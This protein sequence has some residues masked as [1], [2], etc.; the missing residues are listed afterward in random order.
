VQRS[1]IHSNLGSEVIIFSIK[2][3]E[4]LGSYNLWLM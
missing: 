2:P 3:W 1:Q 4:H